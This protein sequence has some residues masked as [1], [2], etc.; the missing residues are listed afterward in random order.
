MQSFK[1]QISEILALHRRNGTGDIN[2]RAK[3]KIHY[4]NISYSWNFLGEISP[5]YMIYRS[6]KLPAYLFPCVSVRFRRVL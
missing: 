4:P 6:L 2:E 5:G 3:K 1:R